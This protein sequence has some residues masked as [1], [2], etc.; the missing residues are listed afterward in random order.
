MNSQDWEIVF[1]EHDDTVEEGY[2]QVIQP[3][4]VVVHPDYDPHTIDNDLTLV[5]VTSDYLTLIILS[6]D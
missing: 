5:K 1:G 6:S 3:S 2:E 4:V